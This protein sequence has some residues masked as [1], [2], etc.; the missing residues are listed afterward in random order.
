MTIIDKI[1]AIY[2]QINNDD[3]SPHGTIIVQDNCD[4]MGPFIAKWEY[5]NFLQPTID[6]LNEE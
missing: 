5:P 1:K 3:F 6:Q 4:G 2:P